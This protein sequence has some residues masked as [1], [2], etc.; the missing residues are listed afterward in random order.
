[1]LASP[2][3]KALQSR[4]GME[5]QEEGAASI[6]HQPR[7]N[8]RRGPFLLREQRTIAPMSLDA[9]RVASPLPGTP[10]RLKNDAL[11]SVYLKIGSRRRRTVWS[12]AHRRRCRRRARVISH[13]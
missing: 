13:T 10:S 9:V 1:M 11:G 7:A 6:G 5:V 8:V 2:D 12:N 3:V 4:L